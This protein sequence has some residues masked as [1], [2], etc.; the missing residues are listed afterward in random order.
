AAGARPEFNEGGRQQVQAQPRRARGQQRRPGIQVESRRGSPPAGGQGKSSHQRNQESTAQI[1]A[2]RNVQGAADV[3]GDGQ[4][5]DQ[6]GKSGAPGDALDAQGAHQDNTEG[7]VGQGFGHHG[8]RE[9]AQAANPV[10]DAAQHRLSQGQGQGQGQD[11]QGGIDQVGKAGAAEPAG[12]ERFAQKQQS[13]L[14]G[15]DEPNHVARGVHQQLTN[16]GDVP[17]RPQGGDR[18]GQDRGGVAKGRLGIL[19]ELGG[20]GEERDVPDIEEGADDDGIG[21]E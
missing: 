14:Y 21:L 9:P 10:Q 8:A 2:H 7:E 17:A 18:G 19:H 20:Q 4:V 3:D 1:G 11:H 13:Q 16:A 12:Q 5:G 6:V 15:Q